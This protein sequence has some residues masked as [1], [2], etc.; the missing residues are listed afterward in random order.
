MFIVTSKNSFKNMQFR[1]LTT[2]SLKNR[3]R[4]H[5]LSALYRDA[6]GRIDP[7]EQAFGEAPVPH[8]ASNRG[9]LCYDIFE[10]SAIHRRV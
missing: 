1:A 2:Q 3:S 5:L 7:N 9:G 6:I 10:S 4:I 8:V